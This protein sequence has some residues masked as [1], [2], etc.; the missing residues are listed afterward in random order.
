MKNS[1]IEDTDATQKELKQF[2]TNVNKK[3]III[4]QKR[5]YCILKRKPGQW[6]AVIETQKEEE[7]QDIMLFK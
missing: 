5:Q 3:I 2:Q 1:K 6:I 7:S 4:I